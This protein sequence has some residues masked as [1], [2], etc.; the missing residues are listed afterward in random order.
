MRMGVLYTLARAFT[1]QLLGSFTLRLFL[2]V[3]MLILV[4]TGQTYAPVS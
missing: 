4:E 1:T 2:H 3:S